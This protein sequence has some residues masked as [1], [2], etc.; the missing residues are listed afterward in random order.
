MTATRLGSEAP[1]HG[2]TLPE[3]DDAKR[4]SSVD[5]LMLAVV[6]SIM[7]Y[8][9]RLQDLFPSIRPFQLPTLAS[10]GAL[11]LYLFDRDRRRRLRHLRHPVAI[12]LC[13]ILALAYLSV[14]FSLRQSNSLFFLTE[15]LNKNFLMAMVLAASVR[16]IQDVRRYTAAML[17]GATIYATFVYFKVPVGQSGR[18]GNIV[19]YDANDLGML[20]VSSI[21]FAIYFIVSSRSV[22]IRILAAATI[23]VLLMVIIKTGSRGA[24]LGL[25]AVGIYFLFRF[26]SIS[27]GWRVGAVVV[28]LLFFSVAGS[29]RY[30]EMM[31][32][33][34]NPQQDYNWSGESDTGRMEIWKRGIGYMLDRPLTGIG[35]STFEVAEGTI[36]PLAAERLARGR[37]VRWASAHN[38]FVEIGAELGVMGLLLF[39]LLIYRA[40]QTARAEIGPASTRMNDRSALG[41][42]LAGSVVGYAV[43]GFFLSQAFAAFSYF[44]YAMIVG[45]AKTRPQ[46]RIALQHR[47]RPGVVR[48]AG[49]AAEPV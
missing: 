11:G 31:N 42:A 34:L 26:K 10:V 16:S 8:V 23:P 35:V 33:L 28:G 40:Y 45:L 15:D 25:I 38:S 17:I 9:W 2:D 3:R 43:T 19:Y 32:T 48:R 14:P 1:G 7:T 46:R 29:E 37:G 36:S 4:T 41:A 30:W 6:V 39:S 20:L 12:Y 18:L 27:R 13:G 22:L 44:L 5:L 47:R 49:V 21:P 24:F